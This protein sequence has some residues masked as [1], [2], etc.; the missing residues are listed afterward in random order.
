APRTKAIEGLPFCALIVGELRNRP[1]FHR[2]DVLAEAKHINE[3]DLALLFAAISS[4]YPSEELPLEVFVD[5]DVAEMKWIVTGYAGAGS[6][7]KGA[8]PLDHDPTAGPWGYYWRTKENEYYRYN[9]DYPALGI[10]T[11]VLRGKPE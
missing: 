6:F 7:P 10:K 11:V 9:P 8:K 4:A 3:G 2:L 1:V 5:S